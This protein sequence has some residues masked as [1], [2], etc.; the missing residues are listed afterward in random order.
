[1]RMMAAFAIINAR[2]G[3][4]RLFVYVWRF[5]DGMQACWRANPNQRPSMYELA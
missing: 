3:R 4:E 5:W 2:D 1:M